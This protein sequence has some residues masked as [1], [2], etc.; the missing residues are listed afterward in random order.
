[1]GVDNLLH[2]HV[3]DLAV[4]QVFFFGCRG[5]GVKGIILRHFYY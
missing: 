3:L 1:M 5:K 4:N 2:N